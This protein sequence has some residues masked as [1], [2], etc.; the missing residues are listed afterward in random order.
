MRVWNPQKD[1]ATDHVLMFTTSV[2]A[3]KTQLMQIKDQIA[4]GDGAKPGHSGNVL[5]HGKVYAIYDWHRQLLCKAD[6]QPAFKYIL[7]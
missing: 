6:Q 2:R 5:S 3:F 4:A 1:S 7:E